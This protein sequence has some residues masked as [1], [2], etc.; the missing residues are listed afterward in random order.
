MNKQPKYK[1]AY[2]LFVEKGIKIFFYY[3]LLKFIFFPLIRYLNSTALSKA[4]RKGQQIIREINSCKMHL[5]PIIDDGLCRYLTVAGRRE[6]YIT[7]AVKKVIKPGDIICD[8]G[9]NI[10]YYALFESKLAGNDGF[11]Y[12]IEPVPETMALL[13]ENV[14]LNNLNNIEYYEQGIG[15]RDG[16]ATMYVSKWLN[17][18]QMKEVDNPNRKL[19]D[20]EIEV[21]VNTL[22]TFI[23]D[24]KY[25]SLI[26]MDV[27]GFEYE[28]F[29][30]MDS[31]FKVNKPL[32]IVMEFHFRWLGLDKSLK[33]F[34]TL[35]TNGFSINYASYEIDEKC[36]TKNKYLSRFASVL[37]SHVNELPL[38]GE[39]NININDIIENLPMKDYPE[40]SLDFCM[41]VGALE[42]IFQRK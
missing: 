20:H 8:L 4:T 29:K 15:D 17:R 39:I 33:I 6:E 34:N 9:A 5:D 27:E 2:N 7:E 37:N 38:S 13:K 26:R 21:K 36:I 19:V 3:I 41:R 25:P 24:K 23:K 42:I 35:K 12:A 16:T 11:V 28:I 32:I 14:K 10:G 1:L 22:D 18:S 30:G 40:N 31:L